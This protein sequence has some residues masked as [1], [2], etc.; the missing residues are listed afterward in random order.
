LTVSGRSSNHGLV[1]DAN[2]AFSGSGANRSVTIMPATNQFGTTLITITVTDG[3]GIRASAIFPLIANPVNDPPTISPL[4]NQTTLEN[5]PTAP[6][7]LAIGDVETTAANLGLEGASS[8][9]NLV[10]NERIIFGGG[11]PDR[12]VT[13]TPA[14]SQTGT[15]EITVTVTDAD[16]GAASDSFLL[17]VNSA[18][19]LEFVL[20]SMLSNG[21]VRVRL[22]GA[23]LLNTVIQV[24]TDLAGWLP[25][26]TNSNQTNLV[27]WIDT[28][29]TTNQLRFYRAVQ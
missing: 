7:P 8:N 4:A 20:S 11:G 23:A 24:S 2:I 28:S 16:G 15:A 17:T 14:D 26:F 5:S 22:A 25:A 3:G 29:V 6:I 21:A 13:V 27:E 10:P 12:T 9:T 19:S 1:P 18:Q